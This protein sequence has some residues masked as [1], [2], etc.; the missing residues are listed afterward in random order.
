M[1]L[2]SGLISIV[3]TLFASPYSSADLPSVLSGAYSEFTEAFYSYRILG[4]PPGVHGQDATAS[5]LY[6]SIMPY[7]VNK[8]GE[9]NTSVK[10]VGFGVALTSQYGLTTNYT[11]FTVFK[12]T[13]TADQ[14]LWAVTFDRGVIRLEDMEGKLFTSITSTENNPGFGYNTIVSAALDLLFLETSEFADKAQFLQQMRD[15]NVTEVAQPTNLE[16]KRAAV[17]INLGH[18]NSILQIEQ[19]VLLDDALATSASLVAKM[20]ET[21]ITLLY[22]IMLRTSD[23]ESLPFAT[24][25]SQLLVQ[26]RCSTP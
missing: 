5:I 6:S 19:G 22:E 11:V 25:A 13:A 24:F 3:Q 20:G 18:R 4:G 23:E 16:V 17:A 8:H 10:F 9:F 21:Q 12:D 26:G 2:S 1:Y 7:A 14:A 15:I